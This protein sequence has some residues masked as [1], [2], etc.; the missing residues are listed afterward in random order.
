MTSRI[1][2]L[3][4][5]DCRSIILDGELMGWHKEKKRFGSK[6]MS[7]DVKKMSP[8]S[9]HQPCFVAFDIIMYNDE[10]LVNMPLV[11]RLKLLENTFTEEE[12]TFIRSK[13]TIVSNSEELLKIFNQ[14]LDNNEEGIVLKKC[15]VIYKPKIREGSGCYKIKAEYSENLIQDVDLI[16][17]G[18]YY[19]EGKHIGSINS[20]LMGVAHPPAIEGENPTEFHAVVAASTGIK[21]EKL[22]ELQMR[23]K[24]HWVKECPMGVIGSS[25]RSLDSSK[26]FTDT[27]ITSYRNDSIDSLSN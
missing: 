6:G 22:E 27:T 23:F 20:F 25:S 4:N 18:G 12:G 1:A 21:I 24:Q 14:H 3:L 19:G 15:D 11:D 13:T 16:I 10:L 2:R 5:P 7:F 9:S 26:K 8:T 17:L